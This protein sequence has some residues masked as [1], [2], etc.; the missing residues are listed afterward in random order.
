MTDKE[1]ATSKV[2]VFELDNEE[3]VIP[4][5]KVRSI[6]KHQKITRVPR[7]KNFVQGVIN[8]RGVITP[9]IDLRKLFE[10]DERPYS[11]HT[12]IIIIAHEDYEVGLIVD[13]ANDV[14][15]IPLFSIEPQP[16]VVGSLK[17]DY[18]DGVSMVE[19]R[20]LIL[21]NLEQVLQI[22]HMREMVIG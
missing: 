10:M 14:M 2:I 17:V 7:T 20:L 3:Y 13:A 8:L 15:D 22:Q 11:E 16:D 18:I 1:Q 12:R 21:L 4:V 9:I 19:E 6:E 5:E